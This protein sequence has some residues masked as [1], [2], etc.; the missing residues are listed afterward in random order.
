VLHRIGLFS[1]LVFFTL[2]PLMD[3]LAGALRF[4]NI[5]P[6]NLESLLPGISPLLSF[7]IY[8]VILD[9]VDYCYHRASHHFGWWWGLHSLH[10]SQQNMNLWSDD[11]NHLLDDFLRDVVMALVAL[12]IGVP[13]GQYVLLVSVSRI[14]QSL[15]HAN[16]RIH[17][18]RIGERLL[19][20]PR[21]HRTH[22]AIGV[23]HESKGKG[24]MGGQL[25]QAPW[26]VALRAHPLGHLVLGS[27]FG[28]GDLIAYTAGV[29]IAALVDK[30]ALFKRR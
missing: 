20:S 29:A 2:D 23:G 9:F 19:I 25:I 28:W 26:L 13:P 18:G 3:A 30:A 14:L 27:T 22:H 21:F 12:G 7:I 10:H 11:R 4:D 24:S 17:F 6:L 8:F 16:V 15:Q 5:H 1:V